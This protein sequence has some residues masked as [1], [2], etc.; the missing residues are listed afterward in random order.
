MRKLA[1]KIKLSRKEWLT[2][3]MIGRDTSHMGAHPKTV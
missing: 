2:G 1:K 3:F